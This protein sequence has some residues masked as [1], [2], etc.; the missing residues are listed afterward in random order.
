MVVS[1]DA[2]VDSARDLEALDI[3]PQTRGKIIAE[4]RFLDFVKPST[5]RQILQCVIGDLYLNHDGPKLLL[6]SSQ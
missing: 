6:T 5:R 3:A 4:T 2:A 1:I